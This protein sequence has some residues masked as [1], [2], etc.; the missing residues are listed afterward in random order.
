MAVLIQAHEH[1]H[2]GGLDAADSQ[3]YG[4]DQAIQA[5]GGMQFAADQFVAQAGPGA[6]ALEVE[7]QS[8]G[9]G[10]AL[11]G[12]HDDRGAVAQGHEADVEAVD[13][14][15]IA[16]VDPGQWVFACVLH[17]CA[18]HKKRRSALS[19]C[20]GRTTSLFLTRLPSLGLGLFIG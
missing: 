17:G 20:F 13:F 10:E 3:V 4:V 15:S 2:V 1:G 19:G 7:G 12:G 14:R 8:V 16:A 11:G 6:L 18:T 5:V 9:L